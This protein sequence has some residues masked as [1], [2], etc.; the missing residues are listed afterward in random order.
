MKKYKLYQKE[1]RDPKNLKP[2]LTELYIGTK[3][4]A[5]YDIK[6]KQQKRKQ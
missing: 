4:I 2:F 3:Y 6:T 1:K 5:Y